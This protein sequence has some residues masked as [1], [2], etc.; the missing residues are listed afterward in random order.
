MDRR[1][2]LMGYLL[3]LLGSTLFASKAIFIKLAYRELPDA[4]V[5]LVWRMIFSLPFFAA[6]WFYAAR[7]SRPAQV[8]P[9]WGRSVV[10]AILA[11]LVG[12]Y[13]A[14]I[15]D[16][17]GLLYVSAQLERLALFTYPIFVMFLG[18]L[19][20]GERLTVGNVLS[21]LL[22]YLGLT[23]IFLSDLSA[24][25]SAIWRGTAF[26]LASALAFAI[27]QLWA[28]ELITVMGSLLFTSI[29]LTSASIASIAHFV[30]ARGVPPIESTSF[31]T[32]TFATA[33]IA[34]VIPSYLV[35]AGMSRIGAQS[36]AMISTIS[37]LFT[38]GLAVMVLNEK[39]QLIE[40]LGT[41]LVVGGIGNH[42]L[43]DLRQ[44]RTPST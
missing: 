6:T 11:G 35:N 2:R 13:L 32:L 22:A 25:G 9:K 18:A 8:E 33:V 14:M 36:T 10:S 1:E 27:Y 44:A 40:A 41:A 42:T 34:T 23:I 3:V 28:K 43:R 5:M 31:M 37:P 29:A 4:M 17:M 16:F 26:V 7:R 19:V 30:I 21:A 12:Y 20:F 38:I 24:T 39:F 15:F